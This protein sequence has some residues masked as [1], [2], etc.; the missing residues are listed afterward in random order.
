MNAPRHRLSDRRASLTFDVESQGLKFIC[1]ASWFDNGPLA[2]VFLQN[3]KAGSMAA[4]NAQDAAVVCNS[5]PLSYRNAAPHR[6][7]WGQAPP[8]AACPPSVTP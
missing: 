5:L 6:R 4:V 3:G 8:E 1:T 2:E 7:R